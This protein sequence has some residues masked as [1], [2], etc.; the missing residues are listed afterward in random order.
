[1]NSNHWKTAAIP[2]K[3]YYAV[4]FISTK[5][6]DLEGFHEMDEKILQIAMDE[7]GF[8][9]YESVGNPPHNMFISYWK[10]MAA[11]EKWKHNLMHIE[12][13]KLG[14]SKWYDRLVTQICKVEH[15]KEFIR[16]T[17]NQ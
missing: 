9:G 7:D 11:I 14:F 2:D 6:N 3:D 5:S 1:M 15:S 4:I 16:K 10:D 13:K 17:E 8:L 12:A